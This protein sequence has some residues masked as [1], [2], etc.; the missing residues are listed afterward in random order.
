MLLLC[1]GHDI[2]AATDVGAVGCIIGA[3]IVVIDSVN[4]TNDFRDK[5]RHSELNVELDSVRDGSELNV[6]RMIVTIGGGDG[7]R[8]KYN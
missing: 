4:A 3:G 8:T 7:H 6:A 1:R 2:D 5:D